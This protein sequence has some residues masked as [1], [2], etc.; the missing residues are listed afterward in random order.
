M[1]INNP[2]ENMFNIPPNSDVTLKSEGQRS[3]PERTDN[4]MLRSALIYAMR[5]GLPIFPSSQ[6]KI[7]HIKDW[8]H[9]ATLDPLLI[10][11]WWEQWPTANVSMP[12]GSA[13]NRIVLDVDV[14][15]G[16][17]GY[18]SLREIELTFGKLPKTVSSITPSGGQHF[19]FN[20]SSSISRKIRFLP[21]LDLMAEDS[22]ILLPPSIGEYGRSYAWE[23]SGRIDE[24]PM[25]CLPEWLK[26]LVSQAHEKENNNKREITA[27]SYW[28][29]LIANGAEQGN[30][31]HSVA[32]LAGHLLRHYVDPYL[33]QEMIL[34]WNEKRNIPPLSKEE[35]VK[36]VTSIA[37]KEGRRRKGGT[38]V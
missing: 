27:S 16:A 31:N 33:A 37:L 7:P 2:Q 13:S 30:R 35:I 1:A 28:K 34:L 3:S 8:Y 19:F 20:E 15:N 14:K 38:H 36:T 24:V 11:R 18:D 12:T 6:K 5:F 23:L 26:T 25:T 4:I 10:T 17:R 22:H 32:Q 29:S 21:G 9:Q